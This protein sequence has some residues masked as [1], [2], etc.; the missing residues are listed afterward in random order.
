MHKKGG[1]DYKA[2]LLNTNHNN[3]HHYNNCSGNK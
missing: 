3:Q 1:P 2:F